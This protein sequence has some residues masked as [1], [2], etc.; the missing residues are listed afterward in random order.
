MQ[1]SSKFKKRMISKMTGP[2]AQSASSLVR[3]VGVSQSSL[4][5]W[6]RKA[7]LGGMVEENKGQV[8]GS[9]GGRRGL[10]CRSTGN[11]LL[12]LRAYLF[13]PRASSSKPATA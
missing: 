6:L 2:D 9:G 1:Y 13:C 12:E 7:K 10:G 8:G 5:N 3:E 4:S 11:Q